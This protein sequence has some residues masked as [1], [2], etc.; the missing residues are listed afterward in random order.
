MSLATRLSGFFLVALALALGGFS[1]TLYLLA[2][3]HFQRDFDERLVTAIDILSAAAEVEPGE[4]EWKSMARV[5]AVNASTEED[6][7]RWVVSDGRAKVLEHCWKDL[8]DED[9][10]AILALSPDFGHI[11]G[12]FIDRGG[13][14]WRLAVRRMQS[15]SFPPDRHEHYEISSAG[16]KPRATRPSSENASSLILAAGA[17]SEPLEASLRH[18]A[19]ILAGLSLGIWILAALVGRSLCN[20]ALLPVTRMAK[21]ACAMTALDRDQRLPSPATGDE[22]DA[23]ANS[24]NGLLD[25]LHEEFD[26]Q[27]RFTGDASH[28]LRTPLTALLGQLEVARRRER[29]VAEY[30]RVLD[31]VRGE[32]VR[33][34]Q[35][36]EALLFMARAETEARQ[37]DLQPLELVSWVREH[38]SEWA[39]HPRSADLREQIELD[40][41]AWVRVH[42]PLLGQLL[43]NLLDNASKYSTPGTPII[44]HLRR[45]QEMVALAVHDQGVGLMADDLSHVFEPFFR[46]AE[47]R[48]RGHAGVGL[49]LAIVQRIAAVFGGTITAES[50]PGQGSRFVLRLPETTESMPAAPDRPEPA[51]EM[52]RSRASVSQPEELAW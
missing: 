6:P 36:V 15:G 5:T 21:V 2:R 27:K 14:H 10:H 47:A 20:R 52:A 43:D 38:L 23:L 29:T 51:M 17:P 13:R 41:P 7:V 30:Q 48:R 19:L 31:D 44:V 9:L 25:R 37:P 18:V 24:F 26:H 50:T 28:Q 40:T 35:I 1:I 33:L 32:A 12:S 8:G 16:P 22:L 46:S 49:G 4:V 34:C 3:S 39:S 45:E 11:H 42:S